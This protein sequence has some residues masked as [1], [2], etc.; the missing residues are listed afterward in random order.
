MKDNFLIIFSIFLLI[1][2]FFAMSAM[3]KKGLPATP[4][5]LQFSTSID[6]GELDC[7]VCFMFNENTSICANVIKNQV[8]KK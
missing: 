2:W 8:C 3:N 7:R 5:P 6:C 4:A 1:T